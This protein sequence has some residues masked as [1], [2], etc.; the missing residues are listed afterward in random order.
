[1]I[2]DPASF[3]WIILLIYF[4]INQLNKYQ[5]LWNFIELLLIMLG[6]LLFLNLFHNM[7]TTFI[8]LFSSVSI[9]IFLLRFESSSWWCSWSPRLSQPPPV[10]PQH[11]K[12]W[13]RWKKSC[14]GWSWLA[15]ASSW[16][17]S[18]CVCAGWSS[19]RV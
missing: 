14:G 16:I 17:N 8:Y 6:L 1:M 7:G 12:P 9:F 2:N 3:F 13:R 4:I 11:R 15:S 5:F 18:D 19:L 10:Q